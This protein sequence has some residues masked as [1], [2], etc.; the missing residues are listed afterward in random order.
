MKCRHCGTELHLQFLDLGSAPP[1]NAY[2]EV[3]QLRAPEVWFPLRLVVCEECWLVQTEDY[4]GRED[5]FSDEYA[6]FSSYSTSWLQHA[7]AFVDAMV[8][9]FGLGPTSCVAEVAANDGYL[10]QYVRH[11]RIP[12]YG[13][14]PTASTARAARL[15]GLDIVEEFFGQALAHT[16]ASANRS[17]DLIVANN[18]LAHVPDI[19]DFIAGFSRLLKP[20]G[21]A[22]FEFPSLLN[23]ARF[24]QFDIAY[25][26]HFSYLSLT[27]VERMLAR[28]GLHVFDVEDIPTQGGSLRVYAQR[29]DTGQAQRE[30]RVEAVLRREAEAGMFSQDFY[31]VFQAKAERVKDELL[32]FLLKA[33]RGRKSVAAY[34]AAAKGNTL[35]NFAGVRQDLVS[36]VAD[37][38]PA[39]QGRVLPGSRI[40]VVPVAEL[41]AQPPDYLL[42][43]PWNI[44]DE[45]K[46]QNTGLAATGTRFVTAI[47][48]LEIT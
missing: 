33:K 5:L 45:I 15:K 6:Y 7:R 46:Q 48:H 40:P 43:L 27:T 13:I 17:A 23:M 4:I 12:C 38:N 32:A 24:N 19:N 11:A 14:E 29:G 34:G 18:V 25:H 31:A 28:H 30:S 21:V 35:L 10:L 22:T 36:Y 3:E 1:A 8:A 39:K 47:P 16:L 26:E 9:R 44:A 41:Q 37:K 2:R 42:I 20:S